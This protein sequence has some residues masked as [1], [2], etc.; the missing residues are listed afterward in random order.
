[1]KR[2]YWIALVIVAVLAIGSWRYA[3]DM[4]L[5]GYRDASNIGA[6]GGSVLTAALL[7]LIIVPLVRGSRVGSDSWL[8]LRVLGV[9]TA[10]LRKWVETKERDQGRS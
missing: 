8:P 1:M 10:Q 7:L 6:I 4:G 9:W 3:F 5:H 2:A